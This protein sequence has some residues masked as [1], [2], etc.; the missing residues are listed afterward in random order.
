[1]E[2]IQVIELDIRAEI[3][4]HRAELCLAGLWNALIK[5]EAK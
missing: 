4:S 5:G 2:N 1:M 3:V